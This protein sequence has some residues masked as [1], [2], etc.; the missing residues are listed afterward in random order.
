MA[1]TFTNEGFIKDGRVCHS[2]EIACKAAS[3]LLAA[4]GMD[5]MVIGDH[6]HGQIGDLL[7]SSDAKRWTR[8]A[9]QYDGGQTNRKWK[10]GSYNALTKAVAHSLADG[11]TNLTAHI[12]ALAAS[13]V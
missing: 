10:K 12:E 8:Y 13:L 4:R 9:N 11:G 7:M 1:I 3:A 2:L 6:I 5:A